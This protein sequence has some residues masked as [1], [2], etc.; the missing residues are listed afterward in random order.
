MTPDERP[1]PAFPEEL[2]AAAAEAAGGWI[3]AVDPAYDPQARVPPEGI[4][5]AWQIGLDGKPTGNFIPNPNYQPS[6]AADDRD[7]GTQTT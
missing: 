1:P 7:P 6:A 3:Y 5:G 4:V 2:R